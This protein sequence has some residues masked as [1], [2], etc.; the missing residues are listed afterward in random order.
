MSN[1]RVYL[2]LISFAFTVQFVFAQEI[3]VIDQFTRKH[4]P[5]AKI[6]CSDLS[7]QKIANLDGRFNLEHFYSCD[8]IFISYSSYSTGYFSVAELKKVVAVE[9]S[10]LKLDFGWGFLVLAVENYIPYGF[11]Y[12]MIC[13]TQNFPTRVQLGA[14]PA[15]HV[16]PHV[17]RSDF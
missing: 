6:E 4:I 13:M 17:R 2:L 15:M 11:A 8:S 10:D 16:C 14:R 9:L 1:L 12:G 7:I 3:T 5:S